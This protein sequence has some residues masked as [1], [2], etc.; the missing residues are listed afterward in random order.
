MT[1]I[2]KVEG[3][4]KLKPLLIS[5]VIPFIGSGLSIL[6]SGGGNMGELYST[7]EKPPL[8]PPGWIFAVIW[9]ILYL[10]MGIACYRVYMKEEITGKG[11]NSIFIYGVQLLLNLL[12]PIL[13]FGLRLYGIAFIE[14]IIL[15]IFI[16]I[17]IIKFYKVD[18]LAGLLLLPYLLWTI[19]AGYL[20]FGVW[21]LNE[22]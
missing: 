14:L 20:N 21:F 12:W 22:M 3:K 16:I 6:I 15:F 13:F 18:K 7:L 8:S 4:F 5:I 1:N 11:S 19:F 17:T 10:L 9:P 2:F